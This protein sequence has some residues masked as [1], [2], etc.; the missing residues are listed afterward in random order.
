[1]SLLDL[2][3]QSHVA[4]AHLSRIENESTIPSPET[5]VKIANVIDGDLTVMLQKANNLPRVIL[6]RLI[7][8]DAAV[9]VQALKR[10]AGSD[11]PPD[12][13]SSRDLKNSVDADGIPDRDRAE[14][15]RAMAEL[16][17]LKPHARKAVIQ[18]ISVL[19]GD[20]DDSE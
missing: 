5:I 2:S 9:R 13:V 4:Y 19:T 18:L 3:T 8:R 11:E 10:A 7:E 15:Q 12:Y 17:A 14:V 6:D 20:E 1:M 16:L